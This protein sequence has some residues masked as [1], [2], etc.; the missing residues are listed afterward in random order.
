[1][2]ASPCWGAV[3]ANNVQILR[4]FSSFIAVVPFPLNIPL[5]K[6][7]NITE[8]ASNNCAAGFIAK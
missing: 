6:S 5:H 7:V 8:A 4:L 1:M 3:L 2:R